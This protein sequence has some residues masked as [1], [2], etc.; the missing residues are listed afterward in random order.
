MT[1]RPLKVAIV[2]CGKIA[3]GHLD[4]IRKMPDRATVVAVCD[5]ELVMAEQLG[6]RYGIDRIYDRLDAMLEREKPD[7][8]HLTTPPASHVPLAKTAVD[9]G[10]HVYVEKPFALTAADAEELLRHAEAAKKKITVGYMSLFD[11]PALTMRRLLREGVVG[12]VVHVE[13]FYGYDLGGAFGQ[14]LLSDADH[15]V[16][17]LP[18]KLFQNVIDHML[19]KA[20]EFVDDDAPVVHAMA[21]AQRTERFGDVRDDLKDELRVLLKGARTS[22]YAT[23]SSHARPVGQFV[24]LYGT[25]NTL[26]VDYVMRTV[27]VDASATLPSAIGRLVP[28]F[29]QASRLL[30]EGSRNVVRFAKNDFH[31]FAG[32]GTLAG[33]FY[34]CIVTD[35]PVP[36]PYRDILRVARVMDEIFRQVWPDARARAGGAE[37]RAS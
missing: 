18:G 17:R 29:V 32:L 34:D 23:F 8:V 28:A 4:E 24:R 1:S 5:R 10:C 26:H 27:T 12:D 30:K 16:H 14:A 31:Y 2:G 13:S 20:M 7:V 25:R 21:W 6:V 22:G 15:W 33:L 11:P 36:I 19:N 3:D 9:A 35:G 37:G